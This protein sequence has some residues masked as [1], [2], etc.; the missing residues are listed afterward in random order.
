V[1]IPR[2]PGFE[3]ATITKTEI[4]TCIHHIK[5]EQI[6]KIYDEHG[7]VLDSY[8]ISV[9]TIPSK[10]SSIK[11]N[12]ARL[13]VN[14]VPITRKSK[15]KF[16]IICKTCK[17]SSVIS[18]VR[19]MRRLNQDSTYCGLCKNTNPDKTKA[20][21]ELMRIRNPA[22]GNT[23]EKQQPLEHE[24]SVH[25]IRA[26][27]LQRFNGLPMCEKDE[28]WSKHLTLDEFNKI[29]QH[30][31]GFENGKTSINDVEYW[32]IYESR[33]QQQ[34]TSV[35][36]NKLTQS[37]LQPNQPIM[38]CETCGCNYRAKNIHKFKHSTKVL[39][40]TCSLCRKTFKR[41][42]MFNLRNEKVVYQSKLEK[43]FVEWCNN[44]NILVVNGPTLDYVF[45]GKAHKYMVDF[46]IP[47]L[48]WLIE[49]KDDHVWHK[50]DVGTGKWDAK[51][52]CVNERLSTKL[53]EKF[54]LIKPNN[55]NQSLQNIQTRYSLNLRE[56]VRS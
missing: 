4:S 12:A 42:C 10:Y 19:A 2:V 44:S 54:M 41:R 6:A 3:L 24:L 15:M 9:T 17:G 13:Q 22:F 28:F 8:S 35:L 21:S 48:K 1:N 47:D 31:K 26:N 37:I 29:K 11:T 30:I 53:Y 36:Y 14:G 5:M 39:C 52:G 18:A 45:N 32:D 43:K 23:K 51:K 27:A 40:P 33:N 46:Y 50:H 16:E 49:I 7:N 34:Y 55:M 56:S 38:E 25:D 20:Q